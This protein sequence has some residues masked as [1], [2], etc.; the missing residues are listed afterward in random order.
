[1][2]GPFLDLLVKAW[3]DIVAL[4]ALTAKI[5]GHLARVAIAL[6]EKIGDNRDDP[7][8]V[9]NV[10]GWGYKFGIQG[11]KKEV[12]LLDDDTPTALPF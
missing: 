10:R 11:C 12:F 1:M 3:G 2:E 9:I 7:V 8:Y 6:R 5:G 4:E